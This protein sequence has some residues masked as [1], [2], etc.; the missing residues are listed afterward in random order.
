MCGSGCVWLCG[1]VRL[2]VWL[3]V[4]VRVW[5]SARCAGA[6]SKSVKSSKSKFPKTPGGVF[7]FFSVRIKTKKQQQLKAIK[8]QSPKC[9]CRW[10]W[11]GVWVWVC[12]RVG[13]GV[14]VVVSACV[15][16]WVSVGVSVCGRAGVWARQC[17]GVGVVF[18]LNFRF[19][20]F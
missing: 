10:V 17:V 5:V 20:F 14:G 8:T 18:L 2:R 7:S 11:A 3:K 4:S 6:C 1:C 15:Y 19:F 13:A 16:V 9:L 12:S